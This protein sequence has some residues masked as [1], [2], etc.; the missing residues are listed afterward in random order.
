MQR[1]NPVRRQKN[2][3]QTRD[4]LKILEKY[5]RKKYRTS[6]ILNQDGETIEAPTPMGNTPFQFSRQMTPA[7]HLSMIFNS[8]PIGS[9]PSEYTQ[10]PLSPAFRTPTIMSEFKHNSK[11]SWFAY[12][13]RI[14]KFAYD[15]LGFRYIV[16]ALLIIGYACLGGYAFMYLE[17]EQ[18]IL[19]LEE[20]RQDMIAESRTVAQN[21]LN[22]MKEY[23]CS[24]SENPKCLH[25]ITKAMIERSERVEMSIRGEGWRWDFWN[26]VFFAATIFTTI[27]YGNLACKT[28]TGRIITIIYGLIGIPLMLFVLKVYGECGIAKA[29]QCR[30]YIKKR[31]R[32]WRKHGAYGLKKAGTVESVASDEIEQLQTTVDEDRFQT[33]PVSWAL[34]IC[35]LFMVFCSMF[36]SKWE[37]WDFL[38]AFYFF[39]VSLSTIGFGD[40]IPEHP[41]SACALFLLYFVGLALF[42]MVYAILQER[43]ENNYMWALEIIDQE[44][45]ENLKLDAV[46]EDDRKSPQFDKIANDM[47]NVRWR[48]NLDR[49]T[50]DRPASVRRTTVISS[51][52]HLPPTILG[53]LRNMT[54]Q[55]RMMANS[56][57]T[58]N[59]HVN[60]PT[61]LLQ[62]NEHL[63][64]SNGGNSSR[65]SPW[66]TQSESQNLKESP[67]LGKTSGISAPN[68]H[69]GGNRSPSAVLSVITEA[70][71]EDLKQFK[72]N[73]SKNTCSKIA[74]HVCEQ[75]SHESL[76]QVMD[77]LQLEA[78]DPAITPKPYQDPNAKP[79]FNG[80]QSANEEASTSEKTPLSS[81][82]P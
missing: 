35:I 16:L 42:S 39:F 54:V 21:L 13:R 11:E 45:E 65:G 20:E 51:E 62:N 75:G 69:H 44:Y 28:V 56:E 9:A 78:T 7:E 66:L 79:F 27:G 55:K 18:Q 81:K 43:V 59:K 58:L 40:V 3:E 48:P 26:S 71:D 22:Y 23:N 52:A 32:R 37:N 2:A 8:T 74:E 46:E 31:F 82:D 12:I 77:E 41:K 73:V 38:T 33:F 50:P 6:F 5:V 76:D 1:R 57:S 14:I 47:T 4:A 25:L 60:R 67:L 24:T 30:I 80:R 61:S 68:L 34:I 36:V 70:S 49:N 10:P 17:K 29:Q 15:Y 53:V 72:K 63:L 64:N 19:D